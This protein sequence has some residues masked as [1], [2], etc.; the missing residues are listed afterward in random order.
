LDHAKTR[1]KKYG[2]A[3]NEIREIRNHYIDLFLKKNHSK[4]QVF[5]N[6]FD[7]KNKGFT[8]IELIITI[9]ASIVV[10]AA[11]GNVTLS[12]F[13]YQRVTE[14]IRADQYSIRMAALAITRQIRHG[15]ADIE[16]PDPNTLK[17]VYEDGVVIYTIDSSG[18]LSRTTQDN[19]PIILPFVP[20]DMQGFIVDRMGMD[21]FGQFE[22][23]PDGNWL[24]MR[25]VGTQGIEIE[26]TISIN[27]IIDE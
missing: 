1:P 27:R 10:I 14:E 17:L 5:R 13:Q 19:P 21:G 18:L 9:V 4:R 8:L 2:D 16:I 11:I 25:L 20:V 22:P 15:G 24:S 6:N 7:K 23:N 26:T 3:V 12:F